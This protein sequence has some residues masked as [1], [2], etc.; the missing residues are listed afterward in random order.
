M[1]KILIVKTSSLGDIVHLLP[2]LVDAVKQKEEVQFDWLVEENFAEVPQWS[3]LVNKV[4]PVAIRRWRKSLL[5]KNTWKEI[6]ALKHQLVAEKYDVVIDAQGLLKS[7]I[8][9]R[10]AK[11]DKG[12]WGY[13]KQSIRESIASYFYQKNFSITKEQHAIT[14]NR[15]LMAKVLGYSLQGLVLDYGLS[16]TSFPSLGIDTSSNY[17]VALHGTSK[18]DKE[19][20]EMHWGYLLE[21]MKEQG[22]KVLFPWGNDREQQRAQHLAKQYSNAVVLPQSSLSHLA[23]L[24]AGAKAVIGMDT[25]LMHIAAALNKS[26][27]GLYPVTRPLL[28]GVMTGGEVNSVENIAGDGCNDR[29]LVVSK[30]IGIVS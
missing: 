4:I 29:E 14:R 8:V 20:P 13:D 18:I 6:S 10:W 1:R 3:P 16:T 28:T 19:W 2:A 30:L 15:E 22:V 11:A 7:A 23:G 24:I 12:V 27:I 25:G 21:I 26:G 9:A 17:I 5:T